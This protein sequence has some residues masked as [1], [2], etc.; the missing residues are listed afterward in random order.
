MIRGYISGTPWKMSLVSH[1]RKTHLF[2]KRI[3]NTFNTLGFYHHLILTTAHLIPISL[4]KTRTKFSKDSWKSL[5]GTP[6]HRLKTQPLIF[7]S[8]PNFL[9][10]HSCLQEHHGSAPSETTG[11]VSPVSITPLSAFNQQT[12]AWHIFF[13]K[14]PQSKYFSGQSFQAKRQCHGY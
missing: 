14:G 2:S 3:Q 13:Y 1:I 9:L 12:K 5:T 11:I 4:L 7:V 10:L 8:P 6:K